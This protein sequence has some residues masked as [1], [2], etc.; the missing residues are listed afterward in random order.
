MTPEFKSWTPPP[1]A[2]VDPPFANWRKVLGMYS[3]GSQ[4][5]EPKPAGDI[6]WSAEGDGPRV[7]AYSIV[8]EYKEQ[9]PTDLAG[10]VIDG[11]FELQTPNLR[12]VR[13]R[14][15]QMWQVYKTRGGFYVSQEDDWRDV[16]EV[17][18]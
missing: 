7:V 18:T 11:S 3:D 1:G 17:R 5:D 13:G 16:P 8:E 10:P 15:Q 12:F 4:D 9:P 14:L 6:N 2:V